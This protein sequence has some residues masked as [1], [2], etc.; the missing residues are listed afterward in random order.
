MSDRHEQEARIFTLR[1]EA[2]VQ[3]VRD[4][5]YTKRDYINRTWPQLPPDSELAR[6]Q[7]EARLV[8]HLIKIIDAGPSS[9]TQGG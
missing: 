6:V 3:T 4:W 9:K 8:A 5:L 7:G 2:G 1:H